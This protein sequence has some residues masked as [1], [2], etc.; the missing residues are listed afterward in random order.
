MVHIS[1]AQIWPV[2]NEGITQFYVPPTHEQASAL[3]HIR[4]RTIYAV[5]TS[6]LLVMCNNGNAEEEKLIIRISLEI[7]GGTP[8]FRVSR[9]QTDLVQQMTAL[10]TDLQLVLSTTDLLHSS[11]L[12]ISA[13][14]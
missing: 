2:C 7:S 5:I 8:E 12:A 1:S 9:F 4:T 13:H 10:D 3:P 11:W 6:V 14:F